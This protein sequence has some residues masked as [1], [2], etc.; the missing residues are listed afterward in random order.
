[1][2]IVSYKNNLSKDK[3][4]L[5]AYNVSLNAKFNVD[6][7]DVYNH[8]F[9]N[10]DAILKLLMD[11]DNLYGFGVFEKYNDMLYLSGMVIDPMYQGIK[12]SRE[13]I[14]EAYDEVNADLVS[15]R[16][17]NIKMARSL[18]DTFEGRIIS[19]WQA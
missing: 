13:I 19:P 1:M 5:D 6:Y 14:R 4:A 10:S 12:L 11:S 9:S 17:Q 8:L 2:K 16:T 3:I 18:I 15:L 7:D